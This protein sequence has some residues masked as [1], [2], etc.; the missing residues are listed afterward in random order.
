MK[1]AALKGVYT[2]QAGDGFL[3]NLA[4][5]LIKTFPQEKLAQTRIY[6]PTRRACR[7]VTEAFLKHT[8]GAG[9]LPRAYPLGDVDED[10]FNFLFKCKLSVFE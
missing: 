7:D 3:E 5:G 10:D 8:K 6:L 9:L 2:I 4:F 1:S